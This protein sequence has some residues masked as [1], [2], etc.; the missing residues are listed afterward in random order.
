MLVNLRSVTIRLA[1]AALKERKLCEP[2]E[3]E[4]DLQA[5]SYEC[6]ACTLII[7]CQQAAADLFGYFCASMSAEGRDPEAINA[8]LTFAGCRVYSATTLNHMPLCA[9]SQVR[10]FA[11]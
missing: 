11:K 6:P 1:S 2:F 3:L 10:P 5:R 4:R 9:I 7:A 8:R